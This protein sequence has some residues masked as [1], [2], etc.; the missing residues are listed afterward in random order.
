MVVVGGGGSG[1]R[2]AHAAASRGARTV[3]LEKQPAVGGKT[4]MSIGI[5]TASATPTQKAAGIR[6]S[7]ARHLADIKAMSKQAGASIDIDATKLLIAECGREVAKL[8]DLGVEFDGPYPEGPH[9]VPR[10]HVVQP[11]C[12]TLVDL[13]EAACRKAGVEIMTAT[14]GF[15][16]ILDHCGRVAGVRADRPGGTIHIGAGAVVLTAG[17]YSANREFLDQVAPDVELAEPLRDFA[18]GDGHRM[19]M[20]IGAASRNM[21]RVNMAQLR[22]KDWPFVEPSPGLFK[23]GAKLVTGAGERIRIRQ[24]ESAILV[25]Y[26]GERRDD[27]YIVV[28]AKAAKGLANAD[29]D[30]GGP[31]RDGWMRTG[32]PFVGT[33]PRVGYAY[34]ADCLAWDWG[35][36]VKNLT[37]AAKVIGCSRA[38]LSKALGK[39]PPGPLH[40]LGPV[41]RVTANTGGGLIPNHKMNLLAT[42]GRPIHGLYGGGVNAR[43]ISFM[44]GHGYALL[45]AMASGRVAGEQAAKYVAKISK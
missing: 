21:D 28:D 39:L 14:P 23:I 44:G 34:L 27:L 37:A 36:Q 38:K 16:L 30:S 19:A 5:M 32:K 8:V 35:H 10:M 15:E 25:G 22:F 45:W 3:L 4:R 17:D 26:G 7:H 41:R 31:G 29:D 11:D 2:A 33:A 12:R 24:A 40:V 9:S 42:D 43:L 18:T 20:R 1:L 6:D 13:L